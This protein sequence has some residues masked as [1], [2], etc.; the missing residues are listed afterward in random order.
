MI[1]SSAAFALGIRADLMLAVAGLALLVRL[2]GSLGAPDRPGRRT[3][4][5]GPRHAPA[6]Q[7]RAHLRGGLR[8]S[9]GPRAHRFAGEGARVVVADLDGEAAEAAAHEVRREVGGRR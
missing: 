7:D 2:I 3:L 6:G 1:G 4:S 9:D 5:R 8:G